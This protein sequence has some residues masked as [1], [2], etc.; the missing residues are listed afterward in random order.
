MLKWLN[1]AVADDL[2]IIYSK[3]FSSQI[4]YFSI[5]DNIIMMIHEFAIAISVIF[6]ILS[7]FSN[8]TYYVSSLSGSIVCFT[9][10]VDRRRCN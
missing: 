10:L 8:I 7:H 9:R 3:Q 1:K 6:K 2:K 5:A 4:T